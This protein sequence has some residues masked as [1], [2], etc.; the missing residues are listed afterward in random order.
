MNWP[1][2]QT[3]TS[4]P[5]LRLTPRDLAGLGWL[6]Q[7]AGLW[8]VSL[9]LR[10]KRLPKGPYTPEEA[11]VIRAVLEVEQAAARLLKLMEVG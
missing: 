2:P 1:F 8:L 5:L 9:R 3:S 11:E 7:R 4:P 6:R 10:R